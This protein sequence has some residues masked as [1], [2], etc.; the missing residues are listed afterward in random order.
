[1]NKKIFMIIFIFGILLISGFYFFGKESKPQMTEKVDIPIQISKQVKESVETSHKMDAFILS[2]LPNSEVFLKRE[3]YDNHSSKSEPVEVLKENMMQFVYSS[4]KLQDIDQLMVAFSSES[5]RSLLEESE[6][7]KIDSLANAIKEFLTLANRDGKFNELEYQFELDEYG[8]ER[9]VASLTLLYSDDKALNLV[10]EIE[11]TG[12]EE[13][14]SY[15]I[16]TPLKSFE[17]L[18]LELK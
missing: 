9:N 11:E 5:I 13:H 1:M 12:D 8:I 15:E 7:G 2:R 16:T 6:I 14:P 18:L 3:H 17:K 4:I 10:I